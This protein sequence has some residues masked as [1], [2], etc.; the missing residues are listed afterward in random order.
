MW[1]R[2][3]LRRALRQ[4]EQ[5]LSPGSCCPTHSPNS[6]PS[7]AAWLLSLSVPDEQCPLGLT[8]QVASFITDTWIL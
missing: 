8:F 7:Y 3:A 1:V 6:T 4:K 5:A 2:A